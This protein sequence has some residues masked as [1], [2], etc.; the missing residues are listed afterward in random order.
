[1]YVNAIYNLSSTAG[2]KFDWLYAEPFVFALLV[3]LDHTK[4]FDDQQAS[5]FYLAYGTWIAVKY[6]IFMHSLVDQ[7]TS[8]L[9]ISFLKVKPIST[10]KKSN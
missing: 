7:I 10:N 4:V 8:Y 2:M 9:N 5:L 6:L 3:Y 1:M